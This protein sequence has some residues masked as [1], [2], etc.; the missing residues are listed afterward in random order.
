MRSIS[1]I[2]SNKIVNWRMNFWC[3][4]SAFLILSA[5]NGTQAAMNNGDTG[6]LLGSDL[7]QARLQADY[8]RFFNL[9]PIGPAQ[10]LENG[11][12]LLAFKPTGAAFRDLVTIYVKTDPKGLISMLRVVIARS[13][14]EDPRNGVYARDLIKS[15]LLDCVNES[16]A[17]NLKELA[18]EIQFRDLKGTL[19]VRSE[20][21]SLPAMPS[22]AYLVV[23][24][25]TSAWETTF[26][27]SKIKL[28]NET[29]ENRPV[30][31]IEIRGK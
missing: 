31:V 14:L 26:S 27:S 7:N 30:L 29:E 13:F 17:G 8:F 11:E 5:M 23:N 19:L 21:P 10:H 28:T 2:P 12:Q 25:T 3:L 15:S 22:G 16:D 18:D 24:G 9:E 4:L 20:L 1:V 6:G